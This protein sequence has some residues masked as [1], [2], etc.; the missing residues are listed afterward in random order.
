MKTESPQLENTMSIAERARSFINHLAQLKPTRLVIFTVVFLSCLLLSLG[1]VFLQPAIYQ[2]YATLLTVAKTAIDQ[3]SREAD[4]QH[5]TIQKQVLLG[6]EL[7][8]ET[9]SRL[10]KGSDTEAGVD[11]TPATIR[12]MLDVRPITDTNLVEMVAEGDDP[13]LLPHLINTWIDVY[14]DARAEEVARSKGSTIQMMQEELAALTAKIEQKRLELEQFRKHNEIITTERQDNE[15]LARLK[16]LTDS[17][18]KASEEEVKAKA[19][20]DT[21]RKSIERGQVVVPTEDT[22]TLSALEKRAQELREQLEELDRQYTRE[23][24]ALTPSLKV[25]PDKLRALDDEIQ[26]IRHKGQS[27]VISEAEQNYA[28]ALQATHSIQEQLDQHRQKA[29]EFTARFT[30]HDALK[31]DLEELEQLYRDTQSRLAQVEA[32]H[33]G[34]YP[35][36]DVIE[37][38]FLPHHPI[39]PDYLWNAM[40][41]TLASLLLGLVA[42]WIFEFLMHKEQEKLAIHLSDIHL[43]NQSNLPHSALSIPPSAPANLLREP[44]QALEHI[45]IDEYTPRQID[46]LF[47]AANAKEKQLL[48]FLLSGLTPDEIANL[49]NDDVDLENNLLT[50]KNIFTR[51]IPLHP[52]LAALYSKYGYCLT[53]PAGNRLNREDL[54]ALLTCLQIDADLLIT[55]RI[56]AET[57]RQTYILYLIRQGM[58]L[59]DLEPVVGYTSPT[60]LSEYG[61]YA[62]PGTRHPIEAINLFYPVEQK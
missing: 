14:L 4:I 56:S 34:R 12:D 22:R 51:T 20:L 36:V 37:R 27:V 23:Y 31:S 59:A 46:E 50:I 30:E 28:A 35:Y 57:L 52:A 60:E 54:E 13:A 11:L 26:Q 39:R 41:V 17:L 18:N 2:S 8:T 61:A 10:R 38:A 33:T 16:G 49:Q 19:R 55:S 3:A 44:V 32:Q 24:M 48:I 43:H 62:P 47:H 45:K 29:A 15:A 5:V 7:L 25:I 9:A 6:P 1:V 42:I 53:D 58:R 40:I 21:I